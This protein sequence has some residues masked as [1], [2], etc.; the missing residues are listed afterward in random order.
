MKH[1]PRPAWLLLATALLLLGLKLAL[2][3][4]VN[5]LFR[6]TGLADRHLRC[7]D[8]PAEVTFGDEFILIGYDEPPA[9]VAS[10]A[11]LEITTYWRALHPGGPDYGVTVN[12]VDA[13]GQRWNS[14]DIR[15][16]RWHR[17]PPPVGEWPPNE[18]A[19]VALSVP[20]L[21]GTPPGV[22]TVEMVAFDQDTLAPLT[23][24]EAAGQAIGPALRLGTIEITPPRHPAVLDEL[25]IRQRFDAPLGPLTL[26]G[27]DLDRDQAA[28]GDPV[29]LVT[30]WEAEARPT[31][32]LTLHL[33]LLD[34]SGSIA[35]EHDLAPSA[36]W[37]PTSTWQRGDVWRGQHLLH[38]PAGLESG[39]YTWR[40]S[41]QPT[42]Q[43]IDLPSTIEVTAPSRTFA[44]P[45]LPHALDTTLGKVATL[46]GFDLAG[47]TQPG[48]TLTVTLVWR[49][50]AETRDSYHVF[51]HLRGPDGALVAQSDGIPAGWTRPTTGWV[52]G[53]Y[54]TD[55]HALSVPSGAPAGDYTLSAGLYLP[56]D[57][58]L[59]TPEGSD[60]IPLTAIAVQIP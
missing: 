58:R 33:A 26:L 43:S 2:L 46:V 39:V 3:D 29:L 13:H 20:V 35:L 4:R 47:K 1:T 19:L 55:V 57:S 54:I 49:A 44:P 51:L 45:T 59:T 30:F 17:T 8:V 48:S 11:P 50:E 16:P 5:T 32:D 60:A 6:P 25:G 22:Y 38:L 14:S 34:S 15:P 53:E 40:L 23:A 12:L 37:H 27:A 18:Y 28:P 31:D 21:P 52:S 24:H 41:L 7:V 42:G 9:R 56:G 10:G 36:P